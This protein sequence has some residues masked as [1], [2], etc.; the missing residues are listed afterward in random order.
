MNL[1]S[2]F[3]H[4]HGA[5]LPHSQLPYLLVWR[6][7]IIHSLKLLCQVGQSVGKN[8]F[9][10]LSQVNPVSSKQL[11]T[12]IETPVVI[13]MEILLPITA[14]QTIVDMQDSRPSSDPSFSPVE[15]RRMKRKKKRRK[16]CR[17][18]WRYLLCS[19]WRTY[20]RVEEKCEKEEATERNH[21][22]LT[23]SLPPAFVLFS[24]YRAEGT[25]ATSSKNMERRERSLE[26]RSK[27]EP[28]EVGRKSGFHICSNVCLFAS[29]YTNQ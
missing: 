8:T 7:L 18:E 4:S 26:W 12:F 19:P 24:L 5:C 11:L 13:K 25:E 15:W 14:V 20:S 22:V 29:K 28:G 3:W 23:V 2:K 9:S 6:A 10:L 16:C 17:N 21:C 1:R 27:V